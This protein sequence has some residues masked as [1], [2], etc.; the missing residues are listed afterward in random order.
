MRIYTR[1]GDE[2]QTSVIGGRRDK[3]NIRIEAYGTIDEVNSFVQLAISQMPDDFDDI[4]PV[5]YEISQLLFD[6]ASDLADATNKRP[7]KIEK[8]HVEWLE[9]LIDGYNE[10]LEDIEH[11]ILPGGCTLSSTVHICRTITRRAERRVTTLAKE[12]EIN[13]NVYTFINRLSDYFFVAARLCNKKLNAKDAVYTR[14]KKV[15]RRKKED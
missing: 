2:G 15:F 1:T 9:H 12:E 4:L 11:F 3:D 5:F 13:G 6:C 10:Q 14:S 8:E 7:R